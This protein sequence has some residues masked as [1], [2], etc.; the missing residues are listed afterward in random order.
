MYVCMYACMYVRMYVCM[1]VCKYVCTCGR[2]I[3]LFGAWLLYRDRLLR[4]KNSV[5]VARSNDVERL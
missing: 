5:P 3:E 4:Q 2:T 1:Y